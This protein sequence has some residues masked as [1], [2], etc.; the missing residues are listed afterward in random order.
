MQCGPGKAGS[1]EDLVLTLSSAVA[2]GASSQQ[3]MPR[4][5]PDCVQA[6]RSLR[7]CLPAPAAGSSE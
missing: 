2:Q 1:R 3:L 6:A 7:L 4:Y 5:G